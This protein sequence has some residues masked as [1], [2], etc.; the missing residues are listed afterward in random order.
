MGN[1]ELKTD[2]RR[3]LYANVNLSRILSCEKPMGAKMMAKR[4]LSYKKF[5]L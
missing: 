1:F 5:F 4:E 2:W 3:Y